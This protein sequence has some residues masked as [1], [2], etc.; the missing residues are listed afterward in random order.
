[1][2]NI[3]RILNVAANDVPAQFPRINRGVDIASEG[4]DA[5]SGQL[6][7]AKGYLTQAKARVGDYQEAA[8]RAQDVNNQANQNLRNQASTTPQS[9]IKSSHSE[10]K[11]HSNIK[12]VPV[13]QS[14]ENQPV[15][16]DNILSN[17]DV[18]SMNTALT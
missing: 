3:E 4:I 6:N 14:G 8:G 7:D 9:A 1:M 18:K 10:G 11:S 5:A 16:S 13:S 12:T 2:P 15:Y 17:S